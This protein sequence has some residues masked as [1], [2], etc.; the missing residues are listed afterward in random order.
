M[1]SI[2][3]DGWEL[4]SAEDRNSAH[5]RTFPIPTREQRE[6]LAPGDGVKL[7]FDIENREN[8]RVIGRGMEKMWVIVKARSE[9]E[10]SGVLDNDPVTAKNPQ[11]RKGDVITFGPEHVSAFSTPP[12]EYVIEK[13]GASFFDE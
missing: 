10:Y 13:Y 2:A 11:L 7:L 6:K 4:V 3:T 8:G 9:G 12:R 1:K 5:P